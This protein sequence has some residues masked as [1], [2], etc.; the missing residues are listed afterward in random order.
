MMKHTQEEEV[1]AADF[2]DLFDQTSGKNIPTS[3][4]ERWKNWTLSFKKFALA[5]G[6][7][8]SA[9]AGTKYM[10]GPQMVVQLTLT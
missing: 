3:D 6:Y 1:M 10:S 5:K 7:K 8:P 9:G 2:P 4:N